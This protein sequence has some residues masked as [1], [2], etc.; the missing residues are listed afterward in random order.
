[1]FEG[2]ADSDLT[3]L[4]IWGIAVLVISF[5]FPVVIIYIDI[6]LEKKYGIE[7]ELAYG[8]LVLLVMTILFAI[9]GVYG[10][11]L[12][13]NASYLIKGI[14]FGLIGLPFLLLHMVSD[15]SKGRWVDKLEI[16]Q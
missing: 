16:R 2:L 14:Y 1:M 11:S 4:A 13:E 9:L 7:K 15:R 5:L 8:F 3:S 10:L 6:R 12:I